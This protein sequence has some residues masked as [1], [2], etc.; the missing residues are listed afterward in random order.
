MPSYT[1]EYS[2]KVNA[3]MKAAGEK[4]CPACNGTKKREGKPCVACA[5]TGK[6]PSM[7]GSKYAVEV[8]FKT[9]PM[10]EQMR[11]M[12]EAG[13]TGGGLTVDT[14]DRLLR[15]CVMGRQ[16]KISY[17]GKELGSFVCNDLMVPWDSFPVVAEN[18]VALQL[19]YNLAVS[20]VMEKWLPPR[21]GTP[22]VAAQQ[23]S[24]QKGS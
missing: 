12:E 10:I 19:M 24:G 2:T 3:A 23:T 9:P 17:D 14:K 8:E 22:A 15:L 1:A 4:D 20:S 13:N 7:F 18:P 6:V 21:T 11:A 5:G 16:V